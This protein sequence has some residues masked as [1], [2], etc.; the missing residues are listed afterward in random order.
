MPETVEYHITTREG[1]WEAKTRGCKRPFITAA[2]KGEAILKTL[3]FA[4]AHAQRSVRLEIR[5]VDGRIE[6]V[7]TYNDLGQWS[8]VTKY[9]FRENCNALHL[10][11]R[12]IDD[13]ELD[14]Y[15]ALPFE[16]GVPKTGPY[17]RGVSRWFREDLP[18]GGCL[19]P[20]I[21][22][23]PSNG[24][25]LKKMLDGITAGLAPFLAQLYQELLKI[26]VEHDATMLRQAL[27]DYEGSDTDY[28]P[29]SIS[30]LERPPEREHVEGLIAHYGLAPCSM[31]ELTADP[32]VA[33]TFSLV[34]FVSQSKRPPYTQRYE[35]KPWRDEIDDEGMLLRHGWFPAF[36][37]DTRIDETITNGS[38]GDLSKQDWDELR[39]RASFVFELWVAPNSISSIYNY[40]RLGLMLGAFRP[41]RQTAFGFFLS[42]R[43]QKGY[44]NFE[45]ALLGE[46]RLKVVGIYAYHPAAHPKGIPG[47]RSWVDLPSSCALGQENWLWHAGKREMPLL[48]EGWWGLKHIPPQYL[49]E[50]NGPD[51]ILHCIQE[52][53]IVPCH[54]GGKTERRRSQNLFAKKLRWLFPVNEPLGLKR[55]LAFVKSKIHSL[56]S[57]R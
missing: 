57:G 40:S 26:K 19:I 14:K 21:Y 45:E 50:Y 25:T 33:K 5:G 7:S 31:L 52:D 10:P 43:R 13:W 8:R 18:Y 20:R 48:H 54:L 53:L 9:C 4:V 41:T 15:F 44:S 3:R 17:F 55:L 30:P 47:F 12:P 39:K 1:K 46:N 16:V 37:N 28:D 51:R 23:H 29:F 22:R 27:E 35:P 2:T 36:W 6:A 56:P 34:N 42:R 11:W 49:L 24:A 38:R 32:D